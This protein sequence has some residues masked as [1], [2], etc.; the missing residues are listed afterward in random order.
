MRSLRPGLS[1]AGQQGASKA[2]RQITRTAGQ[3]G[4][5]T[6]GQQGDRQQTEFEVI[7]GRQAGRAGGRRHDGR[8]ERVAALVVDTVS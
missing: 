8:K 7:R 1:A 5:R 4:S 6:S 3:Q 2:G